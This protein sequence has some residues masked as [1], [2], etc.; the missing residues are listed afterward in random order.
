MYFSI[1]I[2]LCIIYNS[3]YVLYMGVTL[4]LSGSHIGFYSI[5]ERIFLS[6]RSS[7]HSLKSHDF[8]AIEC[9]FLVG[10]ESHA[11]TAASFFFHGGRFLPV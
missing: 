3:R 11:A 2:M 10:I 4:N 1:S 7:P 8:S 5:T 9:L 6:C